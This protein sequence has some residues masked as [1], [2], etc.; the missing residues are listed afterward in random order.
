MSLSHVIVKSD[1][2]IAIDFIRGRIQSP[3]EIISVVH[4]TNPLTGKL[5]NIRYVHSNRLV[6]TMTDKIAKMPHIGNRPKFV[7]FH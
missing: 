4:D 5:L 3:K 7:S 6:S 1:S 2:K